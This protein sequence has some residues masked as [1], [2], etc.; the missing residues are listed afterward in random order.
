MVE[1]DLEGS[2]TTRGAAFA[3]VLANFPAKQHISVCPWACLDS[4]S[5]GLLPDIDTSFGYGNVME[6]TVAFV[7]QALEQASSGR[8]GGRK[9]LNLRKAVSWR[10][11]GWL[12]D[13]DYPD[14][15]IQ[16]VKS[17]TTDFC[18]RLSFPYRKSSHIL[19][20]TPNPTGH[21]DHAAFHRESVTR[22]SQAVTFC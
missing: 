22:T 2:T 15:S 18:H 10:N 12:P 5:F 13:C 20:S 7:S 16:W 8:P 17:S 21:Q 19:P 11:T 1:A 9:R 6:R 14:P 3:Y 4:R